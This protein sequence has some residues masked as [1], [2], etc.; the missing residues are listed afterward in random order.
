MNRNTSTPTIQ[1]SPRASVALFR[2]WLSVVLASCLLVF[3][4]AL[5]AVAAPSTPAKPTATVV[6]SE[7]VKLQWTAATGAAS[8]LVRY[9]SSSSFT[10]PTD[11]PAT[12]NSAVVTGLTTNTTYYFKVAALDSAKATSSFSAATSAKPVH[13]FAAATGLNADNVG[14]SRIELTWVAVPSSPGYR[15]RA[16]SSGN[17][18]VY[19]S[20]ITERATL[21]G[22]KKGT[23]YSISVNVEQPAMNGL[24]AVIQGPRSAAIKVTTSTYDLAAPSEVALTGQASSS[25]K[26]GWTA[27]DGMQDDWRYQIR[28]ALNQAM[29]SGAAWSSPILGTNTT[30]TLSGL[31]VDTAYFVRVRVIDAAGVQRSDLSD[32]ITAKTIVAT[33]VLK[34]K[35]TGAPA[36]DVVVAAYDSAG[37]LAQQV[38][39]K[40]DGSYSFVVRPGTYKVQAVY[41]GTGNFTSKWASATNSGTMVPSGAQALAV[42]LDGTTTAPEVKLGEGGIVRGKISGPD[43][44]AIADVNVAALSAVTSEREVLAQAETDGSGNY[45]LK[46]LPTGTYWLRMMYSTDGFLTRSINVSVEEAK[47]LTTNAVLDN[48][49]FRTTYKAYISGTKSVG[50]TLTVTATAWLAGS[51]PTTRASMSVQWKRNGVAIPGATN[52]T[53]KLTSSDKGK[54]I[55]VTATAVRYGY[56]TGTTTSTAYTVY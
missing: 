13:T 31:N 53:Y 35:V 24:P 4:T 54:K 5:T 39:L 47:T 3:G 2:S 55:S 41:V 27:P 18:T 30:A 15:V 46:G 42:S 25:V 22:L 23:A 40:S 21:T 29:T 20:T 50:R 26:I 51:Y 52:W 14:G 38:D 37:E 33:G 34:G 48:A 6:G 45:S 16:E 1:T 7:A 32:A 56:A 17:P 19:F 28:Y 10:S 43:G 49:S 11:L 44:V 8:Y 9:S 36:G 12:Q